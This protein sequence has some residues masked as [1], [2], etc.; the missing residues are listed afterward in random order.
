MMLEGP[1]FPA[2]QQHVEE[3]SVGHTTPKAQGRVEG[4]PDIAS[5]IELLP[6]PAVPDTL[7]IRHWFQGCQ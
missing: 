4:G 3:S 6:Q 5:C 1:R 7:L 2:M